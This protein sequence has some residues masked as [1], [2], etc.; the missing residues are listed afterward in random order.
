MRSDLRALY[1]RYQRHSHETPNPTPAAAAI[2][3]HAV[4]GSFSISSTSTILRYVSVPQGV[5][6]RSQLGVDLDALRRSGKQFCQRFRY[7]DRAADQRLDD[8]TEF[9]RMSG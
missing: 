7:R 2:R 1:W 8:L 6:E 9:G 4:G 3:T 5:P